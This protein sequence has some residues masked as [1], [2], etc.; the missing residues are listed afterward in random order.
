MVVSLLVAVA[1]GVAIATG[2]SLY[3]VAAL[4]IG[5]EAVFWLGVLLLGYST[6]K[7]VRARG[8][9]QMPAELLRMAR[10]GAQTAPGR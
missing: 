2:A 8:W 5:A 4:L 1:G 3:L 10:N 6:Y 7:A 9:R